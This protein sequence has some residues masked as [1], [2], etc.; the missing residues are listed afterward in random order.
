MVRRD[1]RHL[2]CLVAKRQR[3]P[4]LRG[5]AKRRGHARHHDDRNA[6][7][8][9]IFEFF[10]AAAEDEGIAALQAYDIQSPP[11]RVGETLIDGVLTDT[12]PAAALAD[13]YQLGFAA[14]ASRESRR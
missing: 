9:Q 10:A 7:V 1:E 8:A 6:G 11:R 14:R 5:A 2:R 12:R 3:Q 13:E 4:G